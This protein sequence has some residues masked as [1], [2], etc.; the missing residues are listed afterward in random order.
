MRLRMR[1]GERNELGGGVETHFL[2]DVFAVIVHRVDAQVQRL[3]NLPAGL[4]LA[5]LLQHFPFPSR[6]CVFG[7]HSGGIAVLSLIMQRHR[8]RQLATVTN[9]PRRIQWP[10]GVIFICLAVSAHSHA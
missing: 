7:W 8:G 2:A 4:P 9:C 6:E 1:Y 3:G 5:N 10:T